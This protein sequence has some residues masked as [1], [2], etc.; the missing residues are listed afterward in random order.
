MHK[1]QTLSLACCGLLCAAL[2]AGPFAGSAQAKKN[3][4]Q[5]GYVGPHPISDKAKDGYCYIEVPHVHASGPPAKHRPLYRDHRGDSQFI[6]DPEPYGY[7]GETTAYYGHHP[8]A[9]EVLVGAQP[10]YEAGQGLEYCYLNGPHYHAFAPQPGLTFEAKGGVLWYIGELPQAYVEAKPLYVP[11]NV[12]YASVE[13]EHPVVEIDVP[14]VGYVGPVLEVHM[15]GHDHGRHWDHDGH[16]EVEV[17]GHVGIGVHV[18]APS[19]QIGIGL[20]GVV[21]VDDDHHHKH[22]HKKPKGFKRHKGRH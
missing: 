15:H 20:P 9:V 5:H 16:G 3:K 6:A 2:S 12:V 18:E 13:V 4:K 14:P 7:D 19:L 10:R 8:V 1:A 11:G 21:I 17:S 22:K